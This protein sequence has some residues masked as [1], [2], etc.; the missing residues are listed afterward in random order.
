MLFDTMQVLSETF[1]SN[2]K[3]KGD[4]S[5]GKSHYPT[6]HFCANIEFFTHEIKLC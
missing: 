3:N 5:R 4:I 2:M 6:N 1:F